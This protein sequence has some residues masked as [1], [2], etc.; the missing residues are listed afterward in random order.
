LSFWSRSLIDHARFIAA[1]RHTIFGGRIRPAQAEGLAFLVERWRKLAVADER[2]LAYALATAH[3]E[4]TATM[5][6]VRERGGAAYL[7]RNYDVAGRDPARARANGNTEPGDGIRYAGRGYVQ[8]TWK[9]N[10]ARVGALIG[11]DLVAEPDRALE[12]AI[13][14]DILFRGMIEGWFTGRRLPEFFTA[15]TADWVGARRTVNGLDRAELIAGRARAF[16]QALRPGVSPPGSRMR[17]GRVP[18]SPQ[19]SP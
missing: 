18:S 5:R 10:Y 7:T 12:P 8:L 6:P 19:A 11:V 9:R 1:V 17:L 2:M 3:H 16:Q 14:A 13:A 15:G 4:T